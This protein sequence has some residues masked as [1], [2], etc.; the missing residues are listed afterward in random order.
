MDLQDMMK[1]VQE[2]TGKMREA[3]D[4]MKTKIVVGDAGGGM[5]KAT[6]NGLGELVGLDIEKE[7]IDP[8]DPEMLADLILAGI[9]DAQRKVNDLKMDGIKNLTGGIDLSS[10]G[11]D[12]NN[13]M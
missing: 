9:N 10:L 8:E 4:D 3:Q 13:I 7:I 11:I 1:N 2:M 12:M 6:M 5:V